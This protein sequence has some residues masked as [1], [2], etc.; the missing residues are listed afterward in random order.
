MLSKDER[1]V[2]GFAC[3]AVALISCV[4]EGNNFPL[5]SLHL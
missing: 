1:S 4:G 5:E 2:F 3:S